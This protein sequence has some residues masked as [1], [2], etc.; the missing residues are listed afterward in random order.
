MTAPSPF[1]LFLFVLQPS[2][3]WLLIAGA[4]VGFAAMLA[5]NDPAGLD[6][7][8]AL[9]LFASMFSAST[10]FHAVARTGV[11]DPV[12]AGIARRRTVTAW[13]LTVSAM[14][15]AL[16]WTAVTLVDVVG[17]HHW[18]F[19]LHLAGVTAWVLVTAICW[20]ATLYAARYGAA[21]I[22]LA[23]IFAFASTHRLLDLRAVLERPSADPAGLARQAGAALLGPVLLIASPAVVTLRLSLVLLMVAAIAIGCGFRLVQSAD[24][25]LV[26]VR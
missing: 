15:G 8:Y 16:L 1:R 11:F 4:I 26:E 18:P 19:G 7:T 2:L 9:A 25:P 14:P 21:V 24:L 20:S 12:F 23:T 22:W 3:T 10:G 5:A 13:H 6:Q 17:L